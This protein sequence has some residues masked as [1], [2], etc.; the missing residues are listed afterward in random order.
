MRSKHLTLL[1][2]VSLV[3]WCSPRARGGR[4]ACFSEHGV[5]AEVCASGCTFSEL[6]PALEAARN[7]DTVSLA[8]GTYMG[9]VIIDASITL[10]GAGVSRTSVEGGGPVVQVGLFGA[11]TSPVVT[12]EDLTLTGGV[13]RTTQEA[14]EAGLPG[15]EALGGGLMHP[16]GENQGLGAVVTLRNVAITHNRVAPT[17]GEEFSGDE[18][19][20]VSSLAAGGGIDSWGD[21]TLDHTVVT[22]NRVGAATNLSL[23]GMASDADGGGIMHHQGELTIADSEMRQCR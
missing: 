15:A 20:V 17:D 10:R 3:A 4:R 14:D 16:A 6:A 8:D 11:A 23:P 2:S 22:D 1:A 7:G 21:L 9:G 12:I 5:N 19:V 13:A 18:G